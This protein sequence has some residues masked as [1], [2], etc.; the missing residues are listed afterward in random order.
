MDLS[1]CCQIS[2]TVD[3]QILKWHKRKLNRY[4]YINILLICDLKTPS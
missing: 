2:R 1:L 3:I 4:E